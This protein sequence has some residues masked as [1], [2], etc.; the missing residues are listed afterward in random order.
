[1]GLIYLVATSE[2]QWMVWRGDAAVRANA[3]IVMRFADRD[4]SLV[5]FVNYVWS[6][7]FVVV[8]IASIRGSVKALSRRLRGTPAIA[9]A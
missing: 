9:P 2:H 4:I 3:T 6:T 5:A 7:V 1:M 8:A